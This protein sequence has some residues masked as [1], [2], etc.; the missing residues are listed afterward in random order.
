MVK[1]KVRVADFAIMASLLFGRLGFLLLS[2]T[3][4]VG[5]AVDM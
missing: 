3:G 2:P 4:V 1:S 5:D